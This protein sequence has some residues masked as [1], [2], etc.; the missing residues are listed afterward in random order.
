MNKIAV[1]CSHPIQYYSPWFKYLTGQ[2]EAQLKV[3]YLWDFGVTHKKDAGFRT[4]LQW[5]VPLLKGYDYEFVPNISRDPGTHQFGGLNN[6]ELCDRL[7]SHAPDAIMS[8]GYNYLTHYRFLWQWRKQKTPLIFRGDSHRLDCGR[9]PGEI[10]K[11]GF[12][13]FV[14]S[15]FSAFLFVGKANYNYFR[16]H[17]VPTG[18]LFHAPHAVDNE[19]FFLAADP[20]KQLALQWKREL[21][22][23]EDHKVVLFAGKFE[24]K[25]RPLDLLEAFVTA[26]PKDVSMLF[27]GS[28]QLE[29]ELKRKALGCKN[30][31]FAP[32]QNQSLMPRTY[33]AGDIFV[34][35]SYGAGE[36][37]GLAINEAMCMSKPVIVSSHVGCAGDLV[38]P[39]KNGLIFEAGNVDSLT[40]ALKEAFSDP[41]RLRRWGDESRKKIGEYSYASATAGLMTVLR[42]LKKESHR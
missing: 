22:I 35:P 24:E 4:T 11:R 12:I 23:P 42:Y 29:S 32:F 37:W 26:E 10:L 39:F 7:V 1:I 41:E 6:P 2:K 28:G 9:N 27:V 8:I 13:S 14:Y 31:F 5:D 21:G 25:K 40:Q 36:T 34:L 20:A 30:V 17:G 33:T 15:R 16:Y 18:K 3:F 38:E 19:R